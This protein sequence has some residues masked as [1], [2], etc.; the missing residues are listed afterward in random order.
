[1]EPL[2]DTEGDGSE[3]EP[4]EAPH[5]RVRRQLDVAVLIT[6]ECARQ[7]RLKE[8]NQALTDIKKLL[9]SR[10]TKFEAGQHGLQAH[11]AR[12]IECYLRMVV[13]NGR[14]SIDASKRAAESE[15]FAPHWG[16]RLVRSWVRDWLEHRKLPK[17]K[18]G[19]HV[20]V[21]SLLE[22]PDIC[23]ELRSYL[24]TNKWAMNPQKLAE[25]MNAKLLP[26]EAKKYLHQIVDKERPEGVK[27]YMKVELFP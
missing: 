25:F 10:R 11:R 17:S 24:R 9:V 8:L 26:A 4:I 5:K 6:R 7:L 16:G 27:K 14:K 1:M 21:A 13:E 19:R 22:D 15:G 3:D 18:Q 23:A 12:S 2:L 20:K